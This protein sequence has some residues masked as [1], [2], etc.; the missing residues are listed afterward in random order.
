MTDTL[1]SKE[2]TSK[3]GTSKGSASKGAAQRGGDADTQTIDM[4]GDEGGTTAKPAKPKRKPA[5][6]KTAAKKPAAQKRATKKAAAKKVPAKKSAA[7]KP[8]A[9][10][11]PTKKPAAK[12]AAPKAEAAPKAKTAPKAIPLE[13]TD[14]DDSALIAD[15][16]KK[17]APTAQ[18]P[19]QESAPE[20]GPE[21]GPEAAPEPAKEQTKP[22]HIAP[23]QETAKAPA[24]PQAPAPE[25]PGPKTSQSEAIKPKT[26]KR[27]DG[28]HW[29]GSEQLT[30][31]R[32]LT[33]SDFNPASSG[34][35]ERLLRFAY[36]LGVP[37]STLTAPFRKPEQI[38]VLATVD[39]PPLGNRAAGMALR[40]GHF[41]IHG[42]KAPIGE[43]EFAAKQGRHAPPFERVIHGFS[44]LGDLAASAPRE[45]C[46]ATAERIT[47]AWLN[48]NAK[49][50]K[51]SA[52]T[53]EHVGNRVLAWLMHAPLLLSSKDK[54]WRKQML[55]AIETNARWLDHKVPHENDRLAEIAGWTGVTAAGLLLPE[56]RPRRL[57]GEAGLLKALGDLVAEDGGVLSRSP[58]AQMDAIALLV[59]LRAC[60]E[61]AEK[62]M[63]A[64]LDVMLELLVPPLLALRHGDGGL[65][66]WQGGP[67]TSADQL[68]AL[69]DASGVRTR[70]LQDIRQWGFQRMTGGKSI[71]QFD[72]APPPRARYS[73][74]GCASTLAFEMSD[75]PHRMIVNC[76]GA[77]LA[78]GQVP[79]RIEKGLRASAAHS[80]LV[81][82]NVNSTSVLIKGKLGKGVELV[83]VDRR[84]TAQKGGEAVRV[85]AS[86]DGYNSRF[87]LTHRRILMLSHDG[88]ELRGEDLLLPATKRP[89]RGKVAFAIRFHLAR[90][91]EARVA[92]D[93]R[94]ASM[95][96][97][98]GSLWQFRLAGEAT[99]VAVSLEESMWVDGTGKAHP[100]EQLVVQGMAS[101][102]GEQYSWL[103]KKMS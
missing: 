89:K 78:G 46:T 11:A 103:F 71:V 84:V 5:A 52:W 54:E 83:E 29:D 87:G 14:G 22:A 59:N 36:R 92:E 44:W 15:T 76:G 23:V 72:A 58:L 27:A 80:T 95:V 9:K 94:G 97:P 50:S 25:T 2:G 65:G 18:Q 28:S 57:F 69:I 64:S 13:K 40:A 37:G 12:K 20:S 19:K 17:P 26:T 39:A 48:A 8:A 51:N 31:S 49:P 67:G 102:G 24:P 63:P 41:L 32:T 82:D 30:S 81:L 6:K 101:R 91:I 33:L 93:R 35:T 100:I 38:R 3:E 66:S 90:H 7:K 55:G 42:V 99:G 86:H 85:E 73:R 96:L 53:V 34:P 74:N 70:P 75:G 47:D 4:F 10:K 62:V 88:G 45:Q 43:M 56:G 16:P 98:D 77:G 61:A 68:A 21:S 60:Y 79:L 1:T